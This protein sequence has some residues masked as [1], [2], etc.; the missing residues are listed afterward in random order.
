ML[1]DAVILFLG[2]YPREMNK[3]NHKKIWS[4]MFIAVLFLS[5]KLE[6]TQMSINKRMEKQVVL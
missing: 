2:I 1:N 6:I 4:R 5:P 3:Y